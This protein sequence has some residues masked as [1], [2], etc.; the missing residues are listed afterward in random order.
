M[1]WGGC[2]I[3]FNSIDHA[4]E[5]VAMNL[6]GKNPN[7]DQYY[8]GKTPEQMLR[9]YNSVIPNYPKEVMAIMK[10]IENYEVKDATL[11]AQNSQ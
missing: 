2:K 5:T 4:I 3:K 6:G 10:T 8:A 9:K 11:L 1:G 7:T